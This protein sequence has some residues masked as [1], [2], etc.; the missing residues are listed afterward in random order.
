MV[1][2]IE[3]GR[4]TRV[5][6][7]ETFARFEDAANSADFDKVAPL[8]ADDAVYWFTDGS[9]EGLPAV[10]RAFEATWDAIHDEVYR[11]EDVR[12]I[13]VSETVAVCIYRFV[14]SGLVDGRPFSASGRGTNVLARGPAGWKIVHEHLSREPREL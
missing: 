2:V 7:R 13:A 3:G 8:I 6:H 4:G 10:R 11:I 5:G 1:V 12:W 14:S 9:F